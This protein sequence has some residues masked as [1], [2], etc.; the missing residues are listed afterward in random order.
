MSKSRSRITTPMLFLM[1]SFVCAQGA[2]ASQAIRNVPPTPHYAPAHTPAADVGAA[3]KL[4]AEDQGWEIAHEEP[5]V[6]QVLLQIRRHTSMVTIRYDETNYSIDYKDSINL[7]YN[8]NDSV[9]YRAGNSYNRKRSA[10]VKGPRI[11][12]NYNIWV[13]RL[14]RRIEYRAKKPP[15]A[16]PMKKTEIPVFVADELEKLA[17]L[18]KQGVLTQDE[19][20]AQKAKLLAQ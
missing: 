12:R 19:F 9:K 14:K 8:P 5:G 15:K 6:L 7:N 1:L 20:D 2:G 18:L 13:D 11:H 16:K 3:I 10:V 17:A 4:A